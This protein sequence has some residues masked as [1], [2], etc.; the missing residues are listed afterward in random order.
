M[1]PHIIPHIGAS[2]GYVFAYFNYILGEFGKKFEEKRKIMR[3]IFANQ[4]KMLYLCSRKNEVAGS[5]SKAEKHAVKSAT[6]EN[7]LFTFN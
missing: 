4:Q 3:K 5:D 2:S 7:L 6:K 1:T